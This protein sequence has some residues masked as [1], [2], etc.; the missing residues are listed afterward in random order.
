MGIE[1]IVATEKLGTNRAGAYERLD[2]KIKMGW[3]MGNDMFILI[4]S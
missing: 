2:G 4:I 1:G 3:I